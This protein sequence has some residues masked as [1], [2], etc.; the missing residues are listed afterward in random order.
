MTRQKSVGQRALSTS[1]SGLP[2]ARVSET[3]SAISSHLAFLLRQPTMS[4]TEEKK[5]DP[6][7]AF[8]V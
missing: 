6:A 1:V 2:W 8:T 4:T 5:L 7:L 3:D